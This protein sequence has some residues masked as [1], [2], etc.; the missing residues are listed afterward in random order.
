MARRTVIRHPDGT[1]TEVTSSTS[2]GRGCSA[3]G[4]LLL[5]LF[6]FV[7]PAAWWGWWSIPAYVVLALIVVAAVVQK[8]G[9][10]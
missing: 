9:R 7:G 5:I 1:V 6:L 2:V 4:W 3:F 8:V 10:T